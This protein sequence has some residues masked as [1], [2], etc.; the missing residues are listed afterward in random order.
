MIRLMFFA[1]LAVFLVGCVTRVESIQRDVDSG[2]E[3]E[4]GYLLIAVD[5]NRELNE[6][7]IDGPRNL[8]L[9][10]ADL[11]Q[12]ENYILFKAPAGEYEI[13]KID[14]SKYFGFR[15]QRGDWT[16][17]VQPG[18][19]SYVGDLKVR[20]NR[21]SF[22]GSFELVNEAS[23]AQEFLERKFPSLISSREVHYFGP[24]ED[25]FFQ[26]VKRYD[27]REEK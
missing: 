14:L 7:H 25:D 8:V 19:I 18:V 12:D 10:A 5:T 1:A 15:L 16:F 13:K 21:F 20:L 6:I 26:A 3:S 4:Q 23:E 2:L 24:G 9:T 11:D 22:G 17:S 27:R